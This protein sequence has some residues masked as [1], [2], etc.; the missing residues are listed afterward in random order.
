MTLRLPDP[1]FPDPAEAPVLR[2][3]VL[4]PGWIAGMFVDG[5]RRHTGQRVVAVASRDVQR[6]QQFADEHGVERAVSSYEALVTDPE[7][8]VVYVASPHSHHLDQALAAIAAGKHVLVE[9]PLT[10]NATEARTLVEAARAAGVLAMEAMWTRYLPHVDVIRQLLE[11][12]DLG[13][14]RWVTGSFAGRTVVPDTHRL[15]DPALAGGV[16]LDIGIYPLSF[17]SFVATTVGLPAQPTALQVLGSLAPTGVD[18]QVALQVGY[19]GLDA[20]LFTSMLTPAGDAATVHGELGWL[21]TGPRF[22]GPTSVTL[23]VGD[24]Q[25]TWDANRVLEMDA[26]CFQAA[27][28]ARYVAE[29]R[30]ESPW[31]PLDEVVAILDTADEVRRRL[32]VVYPGEPTA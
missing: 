24:E 12:G 5:V 15:M 3:G 17:A 32:G 27:A 7:V 16:L 9:K 25:A 31:H 20:Q 10:R 30:T 19:P 6:A 26:L 28:L 13:A 29:G 1:R 8:D 23:H 18:A 14:P 22:R 11:N 2:W 4:A 21:E